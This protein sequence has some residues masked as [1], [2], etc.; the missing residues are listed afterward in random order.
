MAETDRLTSYLRHRGHDVLAYNGQ[1]DPAE[2]ART[3]DALRANEVK[4]VVATSALGMGYDK[5]DLAFCLHLGSPD[6]PVAYYQQIGRAGRALDDAVVVL[7]PAETDERLWEY[8]ATA[9]IPKRDEVTAVLE[10]LDGEGA[11][12]SV[13]SIES[14]TGLRRGRIEQLLRVIAVEGVVERVDGG[15]VSTSVGY[16][17]DQAKWDEVR[18]VR[19]AECDIMRAY[20]RGRGCLMMF[21]QQALDDPNPEPCGRCSVCTG[22]L[23]DPGRELNPDDIEAARAFLRGA[24]VVID[25]RKRWP[26]G[27]VGPG[28]R[29]GAIVGCEP[30]RALVFADTPGWGEAVASLSGRDAPLSDEIVDGIVKVLSRWKGRWSA[31]PV[32]VVPMPSRRYAVRIHDLVERIGTVG[33]LPVLD[34]LQVEG[35]PPPADTS[36]K[37]RVEHLLGSLSVRADAAEVCSAAG[38][39]SGL[40]DGP[41]LLV[42]DTYRSG[43]TM[44]VAAAL[45]REAGAPSVLP[46]VVHQL[47]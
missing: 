44:T 46:L 42:D 7:L 28:G 6:S 39:G 12:M 22:E 41:L 29:K 4:A 5:P 18:A 1:L 47:P 23:P 31:R 26:G 38:F 3:E 14:A 15:W 19:A 13:P 10:R 24:D 16:T 32:A 36:A 33:K 9:S 21:L 11:P 2:R 8:F 30:G 43:W 35:P 40:P 45:L 20:A 25:P 17:H 27:V 34:L 37:P